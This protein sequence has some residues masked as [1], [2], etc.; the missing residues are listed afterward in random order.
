MSKHILPGFKP[1]AIGDNSFVGDVTVVAKEGR[2]NGQTGEEKNRGEM[3]HSGIVVCCR[4]NLLNSLL[5]VG[6]IGK[7]S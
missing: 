6:K 1:R 5:A 3:I 7:N 4:N 2:G